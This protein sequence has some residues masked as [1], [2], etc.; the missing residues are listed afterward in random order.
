M[1]SDALYIFMVEKALY[2][3]ATF[4]YI[5]KVYNPKNQNHLLVK[6]SRIVFFFWNPI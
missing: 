4:N 2:L 3:K 5:T 1:A 6:A